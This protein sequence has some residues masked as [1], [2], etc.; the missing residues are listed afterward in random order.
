MVNEFNKMEPKYSDWIKEY[1][2]SHPDVSGLCKKSS[3]E[4]VDKYPELTRVRGTVHLSYAD[5]PIEHWWCIDEDG[6]IIDPTASQFHFIEKYEERDETQP[7]P[8]GECLNCGKYVY[9]ELYQFCNN[10]CEKEF[11]EYLEES[12]KNDFEST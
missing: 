7:E 8:V 12:V 11:V 2:Q 1:L 5:K 10:T 6:N 9:K 3:N 4:M